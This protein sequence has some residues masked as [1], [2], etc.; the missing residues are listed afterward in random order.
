[1]VGILQVRSRPSFTIGSPSAP[2]VAI[3]RCTSSYTA[4]LLTRNHSAASAT[5]RVKGSPG[6]SGETQSSLL[7]TSG[8]QRCHSTGNPQLHGG[9]TNAHHCAPTRTNAHWVRQKLTRP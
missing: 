4:P 9:R 7:T 6:G 5:V 8:L 1:M 3:P 2:S